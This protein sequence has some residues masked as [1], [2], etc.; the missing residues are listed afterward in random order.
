MFA[1]VDDLASEVRRIKAQLEK[2]AQTYP[3]NLWSVDE[4]IQAAHCER[5][6][7]ALVMIALERLIKDHV[8]VCDSR[9]RITCNLDPRNRVFYTCG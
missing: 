6:R 9:W 5:E 4:L 3:D 1:T 2:A 7:D 8:F